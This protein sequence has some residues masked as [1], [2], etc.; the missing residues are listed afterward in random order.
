MTLES[1]G[2]AEKSTRLARQGNRG[3]SHGGLGTG[4]GPYSSDTVG[5]TLSSA[6]TCPT[7]NCRADPRAATEGWKPDFHLLTC[8]RSGLED[9]DE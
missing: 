5:P 1:V 8:P 7:C 2:P 4:S 3:P 6:M 9:D